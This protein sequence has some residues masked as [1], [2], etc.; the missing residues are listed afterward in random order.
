MQK[1]EKFDYREASGEATERYHLLGE[2]GHGI[3][4]EIWLA[5]DPRLHRQ[6][7]IKILPPRAQ[8]DHDYAARFESYARSIATLNH[9]HILPIHDYGERLSS[10]GQIGSYLVMPYIEGGSLAELLKQRNL[11]QQEALNALSQA[12]EALDYAHAQSTLHGDIKP[13]NMLLRPDLWLLLTD[14][15]I[16]RIVSRASQ[17][18]REEA[19][20]GTAEYLAP[21]QA[22]GQAV[23][24]SDRYSLA[25]VAYQLLTGRLPFQARTDEAMRSLHATQPPPSPRRWKPELSPACEAVLLRSLA[26][27]QEERYP[28]AREFVE[29]LT[30]SLHTSTSTGRGITRR[31]L[32]VAGTAAALIGTGGVWAAVTGHLPFMAASASTS[33][34]P[35][36]DAPTKILRGHS[37]PAH[38]LAWLPVPGNLVLAS[39]SNGDSTV[40]LWNLP[41]FGNQQT[42]SQSTASKDLQRIQLALAWAPDAR[43][44][45]LAGVDAQGRPKI[46][47]YRSDLSAP[48]AGL[49]QGFSLPAAQLNGLGWTKQTLLAALYTPKNDNAQSF[50]LGLWDTQKPE[51]QLSPISLSGVLSPSDYEGIYRS[52]A[53]SHD[54]S[55][56]AIGT[57]QGALVGTVELAGNAFQWK[58][59]SFGLLQYLPGQH[60]GNAIDELLWFLVSGGGHGESLFS[61]TKG[62]PD[63]FVGWNIDSPNPNKPVNVSSVLNNPPGFTALAAHPNNQKDLYAAGTQDGKVYLWD[64]KVGQL[65]IRIL[66]GGDIKGRVISLD[67]SPDGS[68]LAASYADS[69]A[70]I[71][72][73]NV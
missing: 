60:S 39:A 21:E 20:S 71:A 61:I 18:A 4:S 65:P 73:W 64:D 54:G 51:L 63:V 25:V 6:V 59:A 22:Q 24:A 35:A 41:V 23:P 44:I 56:L 28:S 37:K 5:E 66:H 17:L 32:L 16:A 49:E 50:A 72:L 46:D 29:A 47:V 52:L 8:Q 38:T 10:N 33:A 11:S 34:L 42:I 31:Y 67:W 36:A 19:Y 57:T 45:A 27:R 68:W 2:I 14:F 26:K 55:R 69:A 13:S 15:G 62:K 43:F 70:S 7:V 1:H 58:P 40:K 9:P 48:A 53:V 12:A 30:P 3:S